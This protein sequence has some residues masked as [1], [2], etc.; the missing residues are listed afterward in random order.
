LTG[1]R[2]GP[3]YGVA[4]SLATTIVFLMAVQITKAVGAG[5]VVPPLLA[6]WVPNGLFGLAGAYLFTR[7]RT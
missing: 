5:G 2:S 7:A 1:G 3:T 4:V 6:A